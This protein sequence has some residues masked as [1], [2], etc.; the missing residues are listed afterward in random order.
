MVSQQIFQYEHMRDEYQCRR[1]GI[2][3]PN[4]LL[5]RASAG[6]ELAALFSHRTLWDPEVC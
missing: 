5:R 4:V 2:A 3:P 6:S 1:L